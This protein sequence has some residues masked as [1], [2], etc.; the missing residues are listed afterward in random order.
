MMKQLL[1]FTLVI[2]LTACSTYSEDDKQNFDSEISEYLEKH[3]LDCK[4]SESG[5]Y[6]KILE[7]GEGDFIQFNDVVFATYQ[8]KLLNGKIFDEQKEPIQLKFDDM[9]MGWKE[10][11][12]YLKKGSKVFVAIPPQLGYGDYD[13]DDI[14]KNS[15][16]IFEI[17]I[18]DVQ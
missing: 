12:L 4:K 16:L 5:I 15:S 10:V 9:I 8:G 17:K 2:I 3:N 14:P 6:Y 1:F 13:L 18:K 11:L 7:E